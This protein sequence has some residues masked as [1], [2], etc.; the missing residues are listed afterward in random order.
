M[1]TLIQNK[2]RF[3][4]AYSSLSGLFCGSADCL[5][6]NDIESDCMKNKM[7]SLSGIMAFIK[8]CI[9]KVTDLLVTFFAGLV[10][11]S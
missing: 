7:R 8:Y 10:F 4:S 3:Q 6:I 2:N 11:L 9:C 5:Y 1:Y